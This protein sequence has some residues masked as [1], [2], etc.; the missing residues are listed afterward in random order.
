M[1]TV[2]RHNQGEAARS[3]VKSLP[4]HCIAVH[5]YHTQQMSRFVLLLLLVSLSGTLVP[6]TT[7]W[8]TS[9]TKVTPHALT[10]EAS[11]APSWTTSHSTAATTETPITTIASTAI[12]E[13]T[14]TP[15]EI[16]TPKT[17][18]SA[19]EA[20]SSFV[21]T[22]AIVRAT[23]SLHFIIITPI[24]ALNT[25]PFIFT[26]IHGDFLSTPIIILSL[27]LWRLGGWWLLHICQGC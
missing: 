8:T 2:C 23:P 17:S 13:V 10:S 18:A 9:A 6:T 15:T 11:S 27:L 19:A 22:V 14:A 5:S 24:S 3:T 1:P 4:Q 16:A 21:V 20:S 7:T 25:A 26:S 12:L